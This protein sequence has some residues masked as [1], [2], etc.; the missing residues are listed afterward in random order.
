MRRSTIEIH[1]E[2]RKSRGLRFVVATTRGMESHVVFDIGDS[3]RRVTSLPFT[4]GGRGGRERSSG[5]TRARSRI[6]RIRPPSVVHSGAAP[7][8]KFRT[9]RLWFIPAGLNNLTHWQHIIVDRVR[10]ARVSAAHIHMYIYVLA[11]ALT[12]YAAPL[13]CVNFYE[14]FFFI[15]I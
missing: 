5:R 4:G 11:P 13:A 2:F 15:H 14:F 12:K 1:I 6:F 8:H 7:V 9:C 10:T 3:L